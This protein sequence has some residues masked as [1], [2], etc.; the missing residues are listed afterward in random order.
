MDQAIGSV[1]FLIMSERT[2]VKSLDGQP[3]PA[4]I[5]QPYLQG[6]ELFEDM[7]RIFLEARGLAAG[8]QPAPDAGE[9]QRGVAIVTPGP[10]PSNT[11]V[12]ERPYARG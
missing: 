10:T 5:F 11:F 6:V 9:G 4:D 3:K 1:I 7:D 12:V 2:H 8:R